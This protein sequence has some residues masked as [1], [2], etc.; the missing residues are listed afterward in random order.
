M[1]GF[2]AGGFEAFNVGNGENYS[3]MDMIDHASS[4]TGKKPVILHSTLH[5][6]D[7]HQTLADI[8]KSHI[9]LGFQPLHPFQP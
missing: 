6:A 8:Q 4:K 9:L 2:Q 7:V 1:G 5:P 3:V